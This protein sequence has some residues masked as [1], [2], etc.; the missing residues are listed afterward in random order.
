MRGKR[1]AFLAYTYGSEGCSDDFF[2]APEHRHLTRFLAAIGSP[3]LTACREQVAAD[4]ERVRA[5]HPDLI[6][7]LPHIGA[8][9]RHEADATQ[10]YWAD[11]FVQEGADIVMVD[12]S[13]A[14]QPVEWR[15]RADGRNVLVVYCP[16]NFVNS[17]ARFDGDASML[18]EAYLNPE[19]GEPFAAAV[20]P[21]YGYCGA[22]GG[23]NR[24]WIGLPLYKAFRSHEWQ[25][26]LSRRDELRLQEVHRIVTRAALGHELSADQVQERFYTLAGQGYKRNPVPPLELTAEDG[27]SGIVKAIQASASVAFVGDGV[28][29]GTANGGYGWYEPLAAAFPEKRIMKFAESRATSCRFRER[30]AEIA[31][32]HA[33]LYVLAYGCNDI[34]YRDAAGCAMTAA[35]YIANV[36]ALV[37][38]VRAATP[39][40]VLAFIAPWHVAPHDPECPCPKPDRDC[41]YAG[42]TTALR[43]YCVQSGIL[44]LDPNP[45]IAGKR[46]QRYWNICMK[47]HIHP[48]ASA[49]IRLYCEGVVKAALPGDNS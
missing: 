35:D 4:F 24:V 10:K 9:F 8:E 37:Q 31:A 5:K 49:G 14:V 29:E 44:F 45:H 47:D 28:T 39:Q 33:D 17:S 6:V 46:A 26:R 43:Q 32:L 1:I 13:H 21:L 48:D 36:D 23:Q 11:V 30:R 15:K 19:S 16:G 20:M 41:L 34:R 12:H 38:A 40:A 25:N 2:F 42:Y 18:V 22:Y 7:V 27:A 3:L